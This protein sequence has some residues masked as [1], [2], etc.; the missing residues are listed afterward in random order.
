[1]KR[2]DLC[3]K[4]ENMPC[5][6]V[7]ALIFQYLSMYLLSRNWFGVKNCFLMEPV[8][9]F[10][11]KTGGAIHWTTGIEGP[12]QSKVKLYLTTKDMCYCAKCYNVSVTTKEMILSL[13][14]EEMDE[15]CVLLKRD[16][17]KCHSHWS[18]PLL[19]YDDFPFLNIMCNVSPWG[20]SL[21]WSWQEE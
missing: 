13:C 9:I 3:R 1:M 17:N 11:R 19:Q 7:W 16:Q 15:C 2:K 6:G 18:W 14:F 21:V 4:Q 5:T 20:D 8:E 10:I 12:N